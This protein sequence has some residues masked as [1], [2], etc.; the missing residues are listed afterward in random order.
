MDK[1]LSI[2]I[3]ETRTK[4]VDVCNDSKLPTCILEPI[5]KDLFNDVHMLAEEQ[6]KCD[7]LAYKQKTEKKDEKIRESNE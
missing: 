5:I 4:L 6:L 3:Q 1:P 7:Q 2:M